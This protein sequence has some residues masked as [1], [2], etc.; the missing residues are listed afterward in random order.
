MTKKTK[1]TLVEPG[2]GFRRDA[3][4]RRLDGG[5][6]LGLPS[7]LTKTTEIADFLDRF[8]AAEVRIDAD[9]IAFAFVGGHRVN[10]TPRMVG[11]AVR[12]G[13]LKLLRETSAVRVYV[14][15]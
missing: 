5:A 7:N 4:L 15:A 3:H 8:P 1:P 6:D 12:D 2:G 10:M 14:K 13:M 9:D 11:Y